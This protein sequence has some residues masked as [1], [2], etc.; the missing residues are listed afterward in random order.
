MPRRAYLVRNPKLLAVL[1]V[2]DALSQVIRFFEPKHKQLVPPKR[3]LLA[4]IAHIGDVL[5]STSVLRPLRTAYPDAEI[6]FLVGSWCNHIVSGHPEIKYVHNFDHVRLN[7]SDKGILGRLFQHFKTWVSALREI[8]SVKY[9]L[10]IDLYFYWPNSIPLIWMSGI[11]RRIGYESGGFGP[12]LT[13]ALPWT[14]DNKHVAE[15]QCLLLAPLNIQ[16]ASPPEPELFLRPF[17][18]TTPILLPEGLR[19][20][21]YIVFHPGTGAPHKEWPPENWTQLAKLLK[22]VG[23]PIVFTGLGER[24]ASNIAEITSDLTDTINLCDTISWDGLCA[25]IKDA[26]LMV[27]VDSMPGHLAAAFKTPFISIF[28][29]ITPVARWRPLGYGAVVTFPVPCSPCHITK[30]CNTMKCLR[31]VSAESVLSEASRMLGQSHNIHQA[32]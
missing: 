3:I 19:P 27:T 28:T 30:G 8:R 18:T 15:A 14:E 23:L 7:R 29:G 17:G 2:A 4:N 32:M 26:R 11:P 9:D 24:E 1:R 6:G 25:V 20:Q 22:R 5:L 10:A 12:L 13:D 31:G 21:G 16:V